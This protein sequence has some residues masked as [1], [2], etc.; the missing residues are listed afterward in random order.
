MI[1][2]QNILLQLEQLQQ[3]ALAALVSASTT[4][5]TRSWHREYLGSKGRLTGIKRGLGGLTPAERP[6][7]GKVANEVGTVLES[8]LQERQTAL[9]VA[10][11]EAE[12]NKDRIDVTLPGRPQTLGKIRSH[13]AGPA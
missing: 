4:E 7:V 3:E 13:Y 12:R 2:Q 9:E 1:E 10:E 5:E 11:L 8:A 6:V